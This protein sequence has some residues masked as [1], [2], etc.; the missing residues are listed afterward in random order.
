MKVAILVAA[1]LVPAAALAQ[2]PTYTAPPTPPLT[3][4][5]TGATQVQPGAPPNPYAPPGS[6]Q[7][8]GTDQP[9]TGTALP[10][11]PINAP[12]GSEGGQRQEGVY[13]GT[14]VQVKSADHWEGQVPS[15][16]VVQK[17]DT[18]WDICSFY[19][20]NPWRWPEV[21]GM[22]PQISNPH[23]IYPGNLV[24]LM[25]GG[26]PVPQTAESPEAPVATR[27]E[28]TNAQLRQIAFVSLADLKAAG[29][30][31]GSTDEKVMLATGDDIFIDYPNGK[32]PQVNT[33]YSIYTPERDIVEPGT[34]TVIGKYVVI[35]GEVS[36]TEVKK[37]KA[38]RG[39]ISDVTNQGV[40]E[41]GERV[42][43][44]KTQLRSTNEV[45]PDASV[46]GLIAGVLAG[47]DIIGTGQVV[48]VDRGRADG[49][50]PGNRMLVVRRGDAYPDMGALT[51]AKDD[52]RFPDV[53]FGSVL[54]LDAGEK[55]SVAW[56]SR[57]D[58]D[59]QV[60]D[61]VLMYKSK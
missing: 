35:R 58:S 5:P 52:R 14:S 45:A 20:G 50:K 48:F 30:I 54:I 16:H 26:P 43:P 25:P 42:G 17:G 11:Q 15:V 3:L 44:L 55:T 19:F 51:Q 34:K 47:T 8:L 46:E 39:V 6:G 37:A 59:L 38:A 49:V 9:G 29:I 18:L 31:S 61:H 10:P 4:D 28:P 22:N 41:R 57:T 56:T 2:T 1:S 27:P 32:P 24:K 13:L 60:G 23:W 36:I 12:G 21:W 53:D 40:I 7:V 33:R